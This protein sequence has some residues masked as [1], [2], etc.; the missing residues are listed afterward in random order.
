M[1]S[2][3]WNRGSATERVARAILAAWAMGTRTIL[4]AARQGPTP[5]EKLTATSM[6]GLTLINTLSGMFPNGSHAGSF[7]AQVESAGLYNTVIEPGSFCLL[8]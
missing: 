6:T 2:G 7:V 4:F 5:L 1:K 3:I 8:N